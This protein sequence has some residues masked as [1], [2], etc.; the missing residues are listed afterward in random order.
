MNLLD[1][2]LQRNRMLLHQPIPG[3]WYSNIVGQL[4]QVRVVLHEGRRQSRV[5]LESIN[6]KRQTVD[7]DDWYRLD[8]TLHSPGVGRR[9]C[10]SRDNTE[11]LF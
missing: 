3:Y 6:G 11:K 1:K 10:G 4:Q 2:E 5:I 7:L 8:L 9:R